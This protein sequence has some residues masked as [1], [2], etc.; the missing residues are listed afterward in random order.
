MRKRVELEMEEITEEDVNLFKD[1]EITSSSDTA[2]RRVLSVDEMLH[3]AGG[4]GGWHLYTF[5]L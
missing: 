4:F 1:A 2:E 5:I 3:E